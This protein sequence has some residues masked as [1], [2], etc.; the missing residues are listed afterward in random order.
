M[1]V[2]RATGQPRPPCWCV[3]EAFDPALLDR[4]PPQ[5]KGLACIC[6][7]CVTAHAAAGGV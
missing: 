3:S 7:H 6:A 1:E 4:L 5:A 2:K